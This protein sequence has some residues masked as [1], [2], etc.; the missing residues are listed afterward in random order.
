MICRE[1]PER[2]QVDMEGDY[3][4]TVERYSEEVGMKNRDIVTISP[5]KMQ[6]FE[7][8]VCD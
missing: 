6:G 1:K 4:K 2:V 5:D 8:K 3:E 7:Q